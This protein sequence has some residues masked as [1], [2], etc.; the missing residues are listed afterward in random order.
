MQAS[1]MSVLNEESL[2]YLAGLVVPGERKR[3]DISHSSIKYG[4]GTNHI[5]M[6][7]AGDMLYRSGDEPDC[8]YF[9]L[10]GA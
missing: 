5:V 3:C 6:F 1:F 7:G 2:H 9:V 4:L 8:V 10:R